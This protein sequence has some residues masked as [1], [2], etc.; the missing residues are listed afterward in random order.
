MHGNKS[1]GCHKKRL[2]SGLQHAAGAQSE[3]YLTSRIAF[4]TLRPWKRTLASDSR[5]RGESQMQF[6][7]HFNLGGIRNGRTNL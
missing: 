6:P 5:L 1:D 7:N 4:V 2:Q 3:L